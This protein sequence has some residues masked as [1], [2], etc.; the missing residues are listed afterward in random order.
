[1]LPFFDQ[2]HLALRERVRAWVEAHLIDSSAAEKNLEDEARRLVKRLGEAGFNRHAVP[3]AYGGAREK[4]EARDLCIL[5][6]ELARGS[7]LADTMFAIQALGSY[8][9]TIAGSEE[10]KQRYL[11][12]I[13][14]GEATG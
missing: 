12:P 8:P 1:M 14:R 13:A 3:Q 5:R 10:Q 7:A 9:I 4:V 11:P 2:D 6:E